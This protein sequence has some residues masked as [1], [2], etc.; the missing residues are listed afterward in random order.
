MDIFTVLYRDTRSEMKIPSKYLRQQ[1]TFQLL[2]P[3]PWYSIPV[4]YEEQC[5]ERL[6]AGA[7]IPKKMY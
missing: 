5:P 3:C 4:I 6:A 1:T 7:K 2:A